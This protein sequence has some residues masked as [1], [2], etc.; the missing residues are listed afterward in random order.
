MLADRFVFH[1]LMT[2]IHNHVTDFRGLQG[3]HARRQNR[4]DTAKEY[5]QNPTPCSVQQGYSDTATEVREPDCAMLFQEEEQ[6]SDCWSLLQP[7]HVRAVALLTVLGR[8]QRAPPV[9]SGLGSW[10]ITHC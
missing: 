7:L 10:I 6:L 5:S 9:H 3:L 1:P 4:P 2:V 8:P